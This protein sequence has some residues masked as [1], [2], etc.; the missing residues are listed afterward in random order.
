ME[1][2]KVYEGL[3]QGAE[4][5]LVLARSFGSRI[6][7]LVGREKGGPPEEA[8]QQL[9][10]DVSGFA[11][12]LLSSSER[13]VRKSVDAI[14]LNPSKKHFS[15]AVWN[16]FVVDGV[17]YVLKIEKQGD[18]LDFHEYRKDRLK[19]YPVLREI[20]GEDFTLDQSDFVVGDEENERL[21][22]IQEKLDMKQWRPITCSNVDGILRGGMRNKRFVNLWRNNAGVVENFVRRA[23]Q[24]SEQGLMI[25]A[26]GDNIFFRFVEGKL[27]IKI[28]DPDC[29][30]KNFSERSDEN[31]SKSLK[32]L[33]AIERSIAV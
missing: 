33:D 20:M 26:L 8:V 1:S 29:F 11:G 28:V 4:R 12:A 17:D 6:S 18:D 23:R 27:E 30:V 25:D 7:Q 13:D 2:K 15:G 10:D 21:C 3:N 16:V 32:F 5:V 19:E 22:V 24:L 9:R 31:F 14:L